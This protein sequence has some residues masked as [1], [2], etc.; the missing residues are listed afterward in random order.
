MRKQAQSFKVTS[1]AMP[2]GL[3]IYTMVT[4][5]SDVI[6]HQGLSLSA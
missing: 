1:S 2:R 3:L 6:Y 4:K 5:V